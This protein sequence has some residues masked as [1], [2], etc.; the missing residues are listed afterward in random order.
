M[1]V[2]DRKG[3][4]S[5]MDQSC[6]QQT[7]FELNFFLTKEHFAV[8]TIHLCHHHRGIFVDDNQ[9]YP[10]LSSEYKEPQFLYLKVIAMGTFITMDVIKPILDRYFPND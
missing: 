10:K 9:N 5:N 4:Y 3:C 7:D 2:V 1:E 8:I 6:T